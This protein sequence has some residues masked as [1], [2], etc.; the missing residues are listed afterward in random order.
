MPDL[1]E[2]FVAKAISLLRYASP[3]LAGWG[4]NM[5]DAY[6][7]VL[8]AKARAHSE[9]AKYGGIFG[10]T[11]S[12]LTEVAEGSQEIDGDDI[13]LATGTATSAA[14]PDSRGSGVS[15]V[16]LGTSSVFPPSLQ[17]KDKQLT[18]ADFMS[19]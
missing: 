12:G 3:Y 9:A 2:Q 15:S 14:K 6:T 17:E 16:L 19:N 4:V 7:H 11:S 5:R 1:A 18:A 13:A 10:I 8:L